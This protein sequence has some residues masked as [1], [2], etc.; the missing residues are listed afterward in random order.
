M[1]KYVY[2]WLLIKG[3]GSFS[4]WFFK[5]WSKQ[6]TPQQDHLNAQL[7]SNPCL[8]R[9]YRTLTEI[10]ALPE[11][12]CMYCKYMSGASLQYKRLDQDI[13]LRM[14]VFTKMNRMPLLTA[15]LPLVWYLEAG[16]HVNSWNISHLHLFPVLIL[17][18]PVCI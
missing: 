5:L 2:K 9:I 1:K 16:Q 10:T 13:P 3:C 17:L 18:Q 14:D 15:S 7:F 11:V 6:T 12:A 8:N 4:S